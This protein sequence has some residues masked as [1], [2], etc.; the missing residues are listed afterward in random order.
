MHKYVDFNLFSVD[1]GFGNFE[2]KK[3][4]CRIDNEIINFLTKTNIKKT[5]HTPLK[6]F[7]LFIGMYCFIWQHWKVSSSSLFLFFKKLLYLPSR[8][9]AL[10]DFFYLCTKTIRWCYFYKYIIFIYFKQKHIKINRLYCIDIGNTP[11][12]NKLY[13]NLW[14]WRGLIEWWQ[15]VPCSKWQQETD[16][17]RLDI[18]LTHR[19]HCQQ[20]YLIDDFRHLCSVWLKSAVNMMKL[21][22]K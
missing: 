16:R 5:N 14:A 19:W 10:V 3:L 21:I 15:T 9:A 22:T 6:Y 17:G 2:G 7:F 18:K 1:F 8:F 13:T 11:D 4:F 12:I 20:I